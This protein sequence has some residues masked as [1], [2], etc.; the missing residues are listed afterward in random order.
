MAAMVI[1]HQAE[2]T[3]PDGLAEDLAELPKLSEEEVQ[4][5]VGQVIAKCKV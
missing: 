3:K 2:M 5:L 1:Q 4:R